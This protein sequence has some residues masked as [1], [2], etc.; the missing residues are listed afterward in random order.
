[1][2]KASVLPLIAALA[3][4][5]NTAP[6]D[7]HMELVAGTLSQTAQIH[8]EPQAYAGRLGFNRQLR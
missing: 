4:G 6:A 8:S 7:G 2:K 5:C 1:M 3:W